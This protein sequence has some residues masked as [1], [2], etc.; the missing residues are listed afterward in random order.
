MAKTKTIPNWEQMLDCRHHNRN[1]K[2]T[3]N[4]RG[5]LNN[6]WTI[7]CNRHDLRRLSEEWKHGE[8]EFL[9]YPNIQED[10]KRGKR[11]SRQDHQNKVEDEGEEN[12]EAIKQPVVTHLA[13]LSKPPQRYAWRHD[14]RTADGQFSIW[15]VILLFSFPRGMVSY[16]SALKISAVV[17]ICT[18]DQR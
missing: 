14:A 4:A 8:Q 12:E 2:W 3:Q 9:S 1:S 16:C 18:E 5:E 15:Y 6:N 11:K 10:E 17:S 7:Q 13:R